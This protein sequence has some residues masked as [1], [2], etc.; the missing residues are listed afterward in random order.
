MSEAFPTWTLPLIVIGLIV[1]GLLVTLLLRL[2][3]MSANLADKGAAPEAGAAVF[4]KIKS[5]LLD[6]S[7]FSIVPVG[8]SQLQDAQQLNLSRPFRGSLSALLQHVPSISSGSV[9]AT[10]NVY[11]LTFSPEAT[12]ALSSGTLS[13]MQSAQGGVRASAVDAAGTIRAHGSISPADG[14]RTVATVTA[15]WQVLAVITAQKFLS[16]ISARLASIESSVSDLKG[17]LETEQQGRIRGRIEYLRDLAHVLNEHDY[18]ELDITAFAHQ[19]EQLSREA[20]EGMETS[21]TRALEQAARLKGALDGNAKEKGAAINNAVRT[22]FRSSSYFL[23]FGY[24]QAL[25]T[26][27]R[28]ALP[29]NR[30][31]GAHRLSQLERKI[32]E[33]Q[34]HNEEVAK[35]AASQIANIEAGT[36]ELDSTAKT[37]KK[38]ARQLLKEI[39]G[40]CDRIGSAILE[41][42]EESQERLRLHDEQSTRPLTILVKTDKDGEITEVRAEPVEKLRR[43]KKTGT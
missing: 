19:L 2:R 30:A 15:V 20:E 39:K 23:A 27:L 10:A 24:V 17:F 26:N 14:L 4:P 35:I 33:L 31:I 28:A 42:A 36:F 7:F 22:Y 37:V 1:C 16:D 6:P 9:T 34:S 8:V 5:E 11:R 38:D 43:K 40:N 29:V 32:T 13:L 21:R 25:A 41:C 12:K 3:A 18:T